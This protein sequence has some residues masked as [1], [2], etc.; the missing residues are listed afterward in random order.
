MTST[1]FLQVGGR[2]EISSV[3]VPAMDPGF[4]LFSW[5]QAPV[6]PRQASA[7]LRRRCVRCWGHWGTC[8][9]TQQTC[10]SLHM[11]DL[12]ANSYACRLKQINVVALGSH[13]LSVHGCTKMNP[14][15][16]HKLRVH[17]WQYMKHFLEGSYRFYTVRKKNLRDF[18][19]RSNWCM[20]RYFT[21]NN[22]HVFWHNKSYSYQHW[23]TWLSICLEHTFRWHI[24]FEN[25]L[26]LLWFIVN[27]CW[28]WLDRKWCLKC[29]Q[30]LQIDILL[31]V[32]CSAF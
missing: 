27:C 2:S 7:R 16:R 15:P 17:L 32:C 30:S 31:T 29:L 19:K 28:L 8:A 4:E 18:F 20:Q 26:I 24:I 23:M 12:T 11:D 10:F 6:R 13:L 9:G 3:F 5:T 25:V 14:D 21:T 22:W 1:S